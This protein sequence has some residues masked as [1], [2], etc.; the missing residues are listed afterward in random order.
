MD[1]KKQLDHI[2]YPGAVAV[3]GAS[4]NPQKPGY[5]CT[6]SLV[7]DGFKGKV[8]PVNPGLTD[9]LTPCK[10]LWRCTK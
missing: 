3:I 4:A 9:N 6:N 2:F 5:M 7:N 1:L 10:A 8:Y